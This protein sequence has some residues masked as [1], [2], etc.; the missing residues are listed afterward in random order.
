MPDLVAWQDQ[1]A[2]DEGDAADI[3]E[4][5]NFTAQERHDELWEGGYLRVFTD[6]GVADPED[7]RI[8]LGGC[9]LFFGDNHPLNTA[10]PV[11]GRE[12]NSYRAELQAV[13]LLLTGCRKWPDKV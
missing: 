4:L 2:D 11:A 6:G 7:T 10:T 5:G 13:R 12:L 8:A 1:K 3:P 9:G